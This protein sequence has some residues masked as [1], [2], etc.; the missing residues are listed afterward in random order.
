VRVGIFGGSFDPVHLGHLQVAER[1]R[2]Q[3]ALDEVRFI[4]ARTQPLKPEGPRAALEDRVAM[5]RAAIAG[6][7]GFTLDLRELDRP[8]PSYTIDT[9]RA[10]RLERPRDELFLLIGA[11]AA[12]DLPRWREGSELGRFATL[13]A[14]PRRGVEASALP[15]GVTLLDMPPVDIS[16]TAIR[17]AASAGRPLGGQVP[18]AVA[19]YI[20]ARGLYR[21][22]V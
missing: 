18:E 5:L 22:G 2:D 3:L 14:V 20:A 6:R 21:T 17:A 11:D 12:R 7:A 1:A 13:V 9:L 19:G 16:A 10:L 8:G 15:A 4:P